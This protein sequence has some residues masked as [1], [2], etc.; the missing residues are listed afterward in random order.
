MG[1]KISLMKPKNEHLDEIEVTSRLLN[2]IFNMSVDEQLYLLNKLGKKGHKGSRRHERNYLKTPWVAIVDPEK[3]KPLYNYF[4]KNI[5][6]CGVFIETN[7]PFS[8][9]K[10]IVLKFQVPSSR[11]LF[12]IVGEIVRSQENGIGIKFKRQLV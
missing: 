12:K 7:R 1:Q 3:E 9:G 4:I 5:S 11:K 10:K 8:V 6:R 2:I